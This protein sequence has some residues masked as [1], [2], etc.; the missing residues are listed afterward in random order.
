MS[1]FNLKILAFWTAR[2]VAWSLRANAEEKPAA[3]IF[4]STIL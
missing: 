3:Y 2:R 4:I 1:T